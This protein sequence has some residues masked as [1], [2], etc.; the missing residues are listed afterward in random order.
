VAVLQ[1]GGW[2]RATLRYK[3][4]RR[5]IV[6]PV[7][8]YGCETWSLIL[9][10]EHRLGVFENIHTYIHTYIHVYCAYIHKATKP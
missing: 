4:L 3:A 1:L 9:R 10:E 6:L 7:L 2:T 5:D 8:L